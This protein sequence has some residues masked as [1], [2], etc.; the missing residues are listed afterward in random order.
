[1]IMSAMSLPHC[2]LFSL[3][4]EL[5]IEIISNLCPV[6]IHACQCT[7]R[8][9]NGVIINSHL[10]QYIKRTALNGLFDPLEPGLSLPDRL[11]ILERWETAWMEMDLREPDS[12]IDAPVDA[13]GPTIQGRRFL[14]GQ[15]FIMTESI[16]GSDSYSFLDMHVT[17]SSH[18]NTVSWTTVD[19]DFPV[20]AFAFA[21]ELDLVVTFS[22]VNLL[23]FA[24]SF[25]PWTL[26]NSFMQ[27]TDLNSSPPRK[28]RGDQ[29]LAVQH[30]RATPIRASTRLGGFR[31]WFSC[32][33][34]IGCDGHR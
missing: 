22:C 13:E 16:G 27:G 17:S 25:L 19:I 32:S 15:Y 20:L 1:M 11:D 28:N 7:C 14:S 8:R 2:H 31:L 23:V 10:I 34:C 18:S 5:L 21:T 12:I 4:N 3:S 26:I 9:L 30:W 29:T 6:D 24:H 33:K